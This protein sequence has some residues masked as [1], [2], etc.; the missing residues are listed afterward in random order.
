M[1]ARVIGFCDGISKALLR[2]A[3]LLLVALIGVTTYEVVSRYAFSAPTVWGF[4][5]IYLLN[6]A[7]LAL[8]VSHAL[9]ANEHVR[10]D[11]LSS[12]LPKGLQRG[13][14]AAF[15]ILLFLPAVGL[16]TQVAIEATWHAYATADRVLSSAWRPYKW[17]F[18]LPLAIG[19][20]ALWLQSLA[21]TL[22]LLLGIE[23]GACRRPDTPS[24][25]TLHWR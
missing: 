25:T 18:F 11:V 4:D 7:L 23:S 17:P 22:R 5:V 12:R 9:L 14:G 15:Y 13:V 3:V 19:L 8:G 1:I 16:L 10:I 6:G 21:E 24:P 2:V 20:A